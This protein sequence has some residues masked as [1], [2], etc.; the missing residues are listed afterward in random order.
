MA[1]KKLNEGLVDKLYQGLLKMVS[2]GKANQAKSKFKADK[3]LQDAIEGVEVANEMLRKA[4]E[5]YSSV[6]KDLNL[7]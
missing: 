3:Q 1:K 5:D 2:S 7:R 6:A 4:T